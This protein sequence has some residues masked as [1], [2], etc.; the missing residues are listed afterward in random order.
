MKKALVTGGAGFI[1]SNL[2]EKLLYKGYFVYCLDD[3]SVGSLKNI[4]NCFAN[5]N[6][7]FTKGDVRT[8]WVV[9]SIIKKV[10]VVFHLAAIVGV[11]I[12]VN[13]PLED[14]SV[15]V[16]GTKN[17]AYTAQKYHKKVVFASSSEVYGKNP[18]APLNEDSSSSIF[19]PSNVTLW[20]YG[21]SKSISEHLLFGLS[22]KGLPFSIVRYFNC[23]GPKGTNKSYANVIP[24]FITQALQNNEITIYGNG[25]QT[26]CFCYVDDTVRGTIL[27]AENKDNDVFNIGSNKE[28]TIKELA[29]LIIKLTKSKSHIKYIPENSIFKCKFESS[30][31]RI[32]DIIKSKNV[33]GFS[34]KIDLEKGLLKTIN[35]MKTAK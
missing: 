7:S 31:R 29:L 19:G 21:L 23:Y 16:E 33:L 9:Q 32:P 5:K 6:F 15:N 2:C 13:N 17:I 28:I 3:L 11:S 1:G 35:W 18:E 24:K 20:A 22:E 27:A 26:R 14:I 25:D 4:R 8:K 34:P 30:P 12:V 10:D